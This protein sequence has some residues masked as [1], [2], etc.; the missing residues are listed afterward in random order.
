MPSNG[1][2]SRARQVVLDNLLNSQFGVSALADELGV[3]RSELYR[4]VKEAEQKS[5]SQF[6]REIR[7]ER[8]LELLNAAEH[9]ITEIAYMVG[10][11]SPTYFSTCFKEYFGYSPS[12][13]DHNGHT[14][15]NGALS[16]THKP[17]KWTIPIIL[18]TLAILIAVFGI[19]GMGER[20]NP[21]QENSLAVLKFDYL[22][23]DTAY[24]Y[25]AHSLADE[26]L[27]SLSN[28]SMLKVVAASSSFQVDKSETCSKI[29]KSL[30]VDYLVDGS[31]SSLGNEL[32][33][34]VKLIDAKTGYQLWAES[35]E[36]DPE[37]IFEMQQEISNQ[38]AN[39]LERTLPQDARS[40]LSQRR[41]ANMEALELYL[42]AVRKGEVRYED[43]IT[44]AIQWL[45]R[46]VELDPNFAE[47]YAELTF[48]YGRWHYY[49]SLN[50]KERDRMM[51]KYLH[52]AIELNPESPEVLFA[53]A[54][55]NYLHGDLMADSTEII[56]D[57]RKVLNINPNYHRSSYRLH[58]VFRGIGKYHTAHMYLENALRL[59]PLN[60]LYNNV[61]ARDLFWKWN[62]REK[63]LGIILEQSSKESPSRGSIY[64]KALMLADQPGGDYLAAVKVI[65][66]ALKEQPYTYGFLFWGRQLALDLDL[67]PIAKKYTQLNQVKFPDNPIY[68]YEPSYGICIIEKRYQDALDLTKIWLENKG[69]DKKVGYS[70][71]ARAHYFLGDSER[72]E[73][74]LRQHFSELYDEVTSGKRT[75]ESLQF[76]DVLPLRT[77][78]EVLRKGGKEE[79]ASLFADFLCAYY[80]AHGKRVMLANKF[81]PLHCAYVQNDLNGF[82][83]I[84]NETFFEPGHRLAIYSHLKSSQFAAFEEIPEYQDLLKK[85]EAETHRMRAEV[86]T[87]LKDEGDWD[88]TWDAALQ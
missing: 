1:F 17:R 48:L 61:Y 86:V 79:K 77:Y 78:V 84:L 39:Q 34:T 81:Y 24:S 25:M 53:K 63:A 37:G 68:T 55:Y 70:N 73:E 18:G 49:G 51:E 54:D 62:Q 40:L 67:M 56:S 50:R 8:A 82:L 32:K 11:N 57:F 5:A 47:A 10:F 41:T 13:A 19:F 59:D 23:T 4:R 71:L 85:I 65:N 76:S 22:G 74:I 66:E 14:P 2:I 15:T 20:K 35:F 28:V 26:V 29:G 87:Y 72:A 80:N 3:S 38:V 7:L 44:Q 30:G 46:T 43:S 31:L 58:Q 45:E 64:F 16:K 60:G 33:A 75:I 52:R 9:S 27:N 42:K 36:E 21:K 69:L 12:T 6:I 88:P 83:K